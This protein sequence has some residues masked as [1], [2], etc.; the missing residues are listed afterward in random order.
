MR[1]SE[2]AQAYR[3][4][5]KT[6]QWQHMRQQQLARKPYCECPHHV[7]QSIMAEIVDHVQPHR[8]DRRKFFD[9][10]NLQSLAAQCHNKFKQSAERGGYGFA[11]GCDVNG[12][13]LV[14]EPGWSAR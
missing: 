4:W 5:Y 12:M 2:A 7:G 10:R 13:P 3:A 14:N 1:R 11:R 8:G 9:P 6:S